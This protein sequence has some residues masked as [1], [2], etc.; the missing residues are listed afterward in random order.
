MIQRSIFI[1]LGLFIVYNLALYSIKPEVR[2]FQN[3]WQGN[4]A[5]AEEYI[6]SPGRKDVVLVGTSM[7]ARLEKDML[8]QGVWNLGLSGGSAATGLEIIRRSGTRPRLVLIEANMISAIDSE[9]VKSRF[10]GPTVFFKTLLPGIRTAYQPANL[11]VNWVKKSKSQVQDAPNPKAFQNLI[12][13]QKD[14]WKQIPNE[15]DSRKSLITI[16]QAVENL[17]A[18]G[19]KVAFFDMP[20]DSALEVMPARQAAWKR[21]REAFPPTHF[22]W[23]KSVP[24]DFPTFDGI[25]LLNQGARRFARILQDEAH[26]RFSR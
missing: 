1:F 10:H 17:Q 8:D 14:S 7:S 19:V 20:I 6:Y 4:V 13:I 25:H 18:E 9:F 22:D 23:L 2:Y 12:R 3:Q 15:D 16:R 11:F 5:A 24:G 26:T 21:M